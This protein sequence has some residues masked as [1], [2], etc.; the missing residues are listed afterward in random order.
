MFSKLF[1]RYLHKSEK[2]SKNNKV[3]Y[4]YLKFNGLSITIIYHLR[5]TTQ[6]LRIMAFTTI[7]LRNQMS[8]MNIS[9]CILEKKFLK[10]NLVLTKW[11]V[12]IVTKES[13]LLLKWGTRVWTRL[14]F[15]A[16]K[17]KLEGSVMTVMKFQ[18]VLGKIHWIY[19]MKWI[20]KQFFIF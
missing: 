4:F 18:S 13:Y 1:L 16:M 20:L 17:M 3:S 7:R 5:Q 10:F 9:L 6:S 19:P 14:Q 15:I 8:N 2:N 12:K 11:R